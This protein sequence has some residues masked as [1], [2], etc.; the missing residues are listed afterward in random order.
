MAYIRLAQKDEAE[1]FRW[2][3]VRVP[4]NCFYPNLLEVPRI[5]LD[6]LRVAGFEFEEVPRDEARAI[7]AAALERQR[8]GRTAA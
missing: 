8:N 1:A 7:R 6:R 3:A 2:L 4:M 5:A